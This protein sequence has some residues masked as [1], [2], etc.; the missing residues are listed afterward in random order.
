MVVTKQ[1]RLISLS[2]DQPFYSFY[3]SLK[4]FEPPSLVPETK[5]L[6]IELQG[7]FGKYINLIHLF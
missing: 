2:Q 7:H 1:K 5:I 6:S 3:V 4:G